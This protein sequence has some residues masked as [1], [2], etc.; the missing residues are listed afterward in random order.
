[1]PA[2]IA[3]LAMDA[4]RFRTVSQSRLV[5]LLW[6]ALLLPIAQ[7]AATWHALSHTAAA[8]DAGEKATDSRAL[9]HTHCDLCLTAAAISGG[10]PLRESH[11]W[12]RPA[13]RDEMPQA[14][15][16]GVRLAAHSWIYRSRAP[17]FAPT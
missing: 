11:A 1:M 8:V 16:G 10:A 12:A 15:V 7:V 3:L 4:R 9:H 6:L 5:W 14:A 17:P 2:K 13:A